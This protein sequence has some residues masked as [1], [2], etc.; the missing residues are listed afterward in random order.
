MDSSVERRARAAGAV[1][2]TQASRPP[3]L[4]VPRPGVRAT[5]RALNM[6]PDSR[7][8][9]VRGGQDLS[10]NLKTHEREADLLQVCSASSGSAACLAFPGP[11]PRIWADAMGG[12][13]RS[14]G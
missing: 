11:Q 1:P 4:P 6:Q 12:A 8:T 5:A 3:S 9:H 10:A 14:L 7:V 13:L 2:G